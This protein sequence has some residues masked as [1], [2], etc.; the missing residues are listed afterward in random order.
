VLIGLTML[1]LLLAGVASLLYIRQGAPVAEQPPASDGLPEKRGKEHSSEQHPTINPTAPSADDEPG[2]PE[3][4]ATAATTPTPT[5]AAFFD[6]QRFSYAPGFY[7]DELQSYL[8]KQPGQLKD[9]RFQIGS[10]SHSLAAV[11]V[12]Q[13]SLFSFNPRIVLALLEQQSRLLSDP[14]PSDEQF[15]RALGFESEEVRH[16]GLY[17]QLIWGIREIRYAMRDY[18]IQG[19][20]GALPPLVFA[21]DEEQAYT[22]DADT[23]PAH[24]VL[25]RVLAR[26]TTADMLPRK[27]DTFL[28]TYM[29]LFGDP[30]L[31]LPDLPPPAEPFLA[32]PMERPYMVTSFFD[33]DTPFLQRN[34]SLLSFWGV[35]EA[36]LSYDGHTGWDY[37]MMYADAVLAAA[38]GRVV[39]V[40]NSDDGCASPSYSI[41]LEHGN[42]YRTLYWHLNTLD[43]E[44]GQQVQQGA[45][46]GYAGETGCAFG[47][48]LHFQVQY[49]GRD[50]DPYGWC[51]DSPDPWAAN[52]L[53][54]Q[55]VWLWED[56]LNPCGTPP[57]DAVVVDNSS[58]GFAIHGEW[59]RSQ[60]GY[61]GG[62]L[63]TA[64]KWLNT[65][66]QPWEMRRLVEAPAVAV[67]KPDL[68]RAARYR[69]LAYIPYILN[70]LD[71]S[72]AIRYRVRHSEGE[73]A[74][75]VN[76]EST[77][78][79]W[80][81]LGIYSFD[82]AQQPRV[83][84]ST[85][86]GDEA[87]GLWADAVV[88]LPV[89]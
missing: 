31:P 41:I 63:F 77:A 66:R 23:G 10:R 49:L 3:P 58:P 12:N 42:G 65:E 76:A 82:P 60:L 9:V 24:Y 54:Q 46:L 55:S 4:T 22:A 40:G 44:T 2:Q 30:R 87:R 35:E 61:G 38:E 72:R 20:R 89:P 15:I 17:A 19:P 51:G 18:A 14:N 88:W 33:H 16:K 25:S 78:N 52:P 27:L 64:T 53:G 71:D 7:Q 34:G 85:L 67:W 84:L 56:M 75:V 37:A 1:A 50:V 26:T 62:A 73:T 11:L 21:D 70:G 79:A 48:H 80:A 39:F 8:D 47:P 69:V 59:Q 6:P 81:D 13:C 83:S 28:L 74:V 45:L 5:G 68:P 36:A 32:R 86:A 29:R 57:P 43:V